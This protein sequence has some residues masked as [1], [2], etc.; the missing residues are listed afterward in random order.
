[1][2]MEFSMRFVCVCVLWCCG[3]SVRS[4]L[5]YLAPSGDPKLNLSDR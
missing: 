4:S 5:S 3:G 2:K 1:M